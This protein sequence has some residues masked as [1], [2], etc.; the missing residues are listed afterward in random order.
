MM[1]NGVGFQPLHA[2]YLLTPG[3]TDDLRI[4]L[5]LRASSTRRQIRLSISTIHLG[6]LHPISAYNRTLYCSIVAYTVIGVNNLLL[7]QGVAP[8]KLLALHDRHKLQH[9]LTDKRPQYWHLLLE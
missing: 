6:L 5:A 9:R 2:V 7:I 4:W 8:I 3:P 1:E